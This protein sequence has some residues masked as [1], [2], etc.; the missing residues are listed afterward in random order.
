MYKAIG[1]WSCPDEIEAFRC[2]R[3]REALELRE[4]RAGS[5]VQIVEREH[6]QRARRDGLSGALALEK[7]GGAYRLRL[8]RRSS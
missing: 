8:Q 3:A 2:F 4:K 7:S 5:V 6:L 1:A